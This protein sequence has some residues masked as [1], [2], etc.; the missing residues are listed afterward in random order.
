MLLVLVSGQ[1][2]QTIHML[3]V[4]DM[5]VSDNGFTFVVVNH[6][7]QS[8]PATTTQSLSLF[9]LKTLAFVLLQPVRSI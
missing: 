8:R 7:K 1:W 2:G 3:D 4:N 5:T 6:L 9:L